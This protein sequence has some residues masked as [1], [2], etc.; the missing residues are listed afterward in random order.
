[1]DYIQHNIE[2]IR[3]KID[4]AAQQSGRN[5]SEIILVAVSKT[6]GLEQVEQAFNFG[7]RDFGENRSR[8]LALKQARFPEARWHMIGQLQTN[9][10][11][12]VIG[13]ANLIH[14]LDR[15][16][17]AEALNREAERQSITV[18]ALLEIN[19]AGEAQKAG[20]D[21]GE[22]KSFLEAMVKLPHLRIMGLMTMAPLSDDPETSRPVFRTLH[23]LFTTYQ[24]IPPGGNVQMQYLSMGMSQ[25]FEVAVQEG[26]NIVR[27]GTA[28]FAK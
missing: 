7:I 28:I 2:D 4:I 14:S 24:K 8:E 9:K 23:N 26:A 1:M 3:K 10:V 13:K 17:L 15:W 5:A 25:D 19:A 12:E 11:K 18:D 22:V 20:L 6:V 16:T 27:V 21:A